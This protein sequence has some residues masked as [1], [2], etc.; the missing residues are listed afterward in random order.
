M[1]WNLLV[2]WPVSRKKTQHCQFNKTKEAEK[3]H[4]TETP[5]VLTFFQG[6]GQGSRDWK[7]GSIGMPEHLCS[8]D[9]SHVALTGYCNLL[10]AVGFLDSLLFL[11]LLFI[12]YVS[13][14]CELHVE[15]I[16]PDHY[17]Y[18]VRSSALSLSPSRWFHWTSM[19]KL[20]IC[21]Y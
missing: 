5:L 16:P 19:H 18:F 9:W 1:K 3:I 10:F 20:S 14:R 21:M 12:V 4:R 6:S 8:S 17:P 7:R 11:L 2:L 13:C 15:Y